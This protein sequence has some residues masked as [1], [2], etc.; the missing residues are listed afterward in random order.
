MANQNTRLIEDIQK[1]ITEAESRIRKHIRETP[2]EYSHFLSRQGDCR[3]YLKLECAQISGSFKYRGALNKYLSMSDQKRLEPVITASSGNHG[4]AL[5]H[6]IHSFG[7]QGK[8]F[9]PENASPA[10]IED[11][12]RHGVE[13]VLHGHDCIMS[14]TLAKNTARQDGLE[15]ISPYNDPK[16]IGGQGTIAVE[17]VRQMEQPDDVLV[18]VGGGG[19]VSGIAA[20]LKGISSKIQVIGCQPRASAV[21]YE[22]IK[23]G[24]IIEMDS[25]PTLADGT[26]GGVDP[27]SITFPI[28]RDLIDRFTLVSEERIKK[29]I[30]FALEHHQILIEGA[31][32]LPIAV[33]LKEIERFKGRNVVL[34]ISGKRISLDK[35]TRILIDSCSS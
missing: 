19:L 20:H 15:F 31:A 7:G 22:S 27:D 18:P 14:E 16:I 29:A 10:K 28:C 30:V 33:F 1:E 34:V 8:I 25:E 26:A 9:I 12:K 2:L 3:V 23:A 13:L 5:A 21:M 35:L 4:A 32:A 6:I 24:D 17:V 11:L